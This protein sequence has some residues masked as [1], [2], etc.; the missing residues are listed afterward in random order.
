M[1]ISLNRLAAPGSR[2]ASCVPSKGLPLLM[3]TLLNDQP[4]KPV[5]KLGFGTKFIHPGSIFGA[6]EAGEYKQPGLL[7]A[8]PKEDG[9]KVLHC[10]FLAIIVSTAFCRNQYINM[11]FTPGSFDT[12]AGPSNP[13]ASLKNVKNVGAGCPAR[14]IFLPK[15]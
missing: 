11:I 9:L 7:V 5:S 8:H 12:S 6:A 2:F 13:Y 1:G 4:A 15:W 14:P 3:L 10:K